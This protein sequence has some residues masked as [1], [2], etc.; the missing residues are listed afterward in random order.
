MYYVVLILIYYCQTLGFFNNHAFLFDRCVAVDCRQLYLHHKN[1][2]VIFTDEFQTVVSSIRVW[3]NYF[4]YLNDVKVVNR[5]LIW[6]VV[7][8]EMHMVIF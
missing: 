2:T 6:L 3:Q 1:V 5:E 8:Y 7:R 4:A